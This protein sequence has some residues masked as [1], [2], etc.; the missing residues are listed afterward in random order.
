MTI[1]VLNKKALL[2]FVESGRFQSFSFLPITKHRALSQIKNPR[3][4]EDDSLLFLATENG[5]LAGYLGCFPDDFLTENGNV[6]F[7]WLSTL[8]VSPDF[9]GKKIAQ[10]LLQ[11]AFEI[12]QNRI[13]ITEFTPEA[14]SLYNKLNVFKYSIPK[15]GMRYFIRWNLHEIL[16]LKKPFLG[17]FKGVLNLADRLGN[18]FLDLKKTEHPTI[19]TEILAEPDQESRD[20]ISR[21]QCHRNSETIQWFFQFPWVL[22]GDEPISSYQFSS[23]S[24]LFQYSVLKVFNPQNQLDSVSILLNRN[25]H[26]KVLYLFANEDMKYFVKGFKTFVY[27]HKIHTI[28]SYQTFLNE[29][30]SKLTNWKLYEKPMERRYLFHQKLLEKLPENFEYS[31]QDGDGDCALT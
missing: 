26:L 15:T 1:E 23:Y 22:E 14:E 8:F 12:Y 31:F 29:E 5:K 10:N 27:E 4:S 13:A 3:A 2:E 25:G 16:P 24:K 18:V 30:L 28:T 21:F 17:H 19:K 9:R 11:K 20:F 6:H 7:A